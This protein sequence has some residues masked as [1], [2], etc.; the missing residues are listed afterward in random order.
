MFSQKSQTTPMGNNEHV[1]SLRVVCAFAFLIDN[2]IH[3]LHCDI[4]SVAG[5]Y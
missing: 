4:N 5:A 3:V 1:V 2:P